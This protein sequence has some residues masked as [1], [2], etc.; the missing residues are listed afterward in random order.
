[1]RDVLYK[2]LLPSCHGSVRSTCCN[3]DEEKNTTTPRWT[4]NFLPLCLLLHCSC[5][6]RNIMWFH[7][8]ITVKEQDWLSSVR[9]HASNGNDWT[10]KNG[11]LKPGMLVSQ[12][13]RWKRLPTRRHEAGSYGAYRTKTTQG[14]TQQFAHL[15]VWHPLCAPRHSWQ[16]KWLFVKLIYLNLHK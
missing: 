11:C 5:N 14:E 6:N 10:F 16:R 13:E 2:K 8:L 4:F 15:K 1:M 12:E 9:I 3:K 7:P